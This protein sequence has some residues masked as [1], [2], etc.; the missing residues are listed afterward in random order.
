M[1]HARPFKDAADL[2]R[3]AEKFWREMGEPE[4]LEAFSHHPRIGAKSL[5]GLSPWPA[6]EQSGVQQADDQTRTRLDEFNQKY[7]EKF[8]FIYLICDTGKSADEM[9]SILAS[10]IRNDRDQELQIAAQE[11][12]KITKLRLEKL[13]KS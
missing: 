1:L 12:G 6:Q 5:T 10:R 4:F 13:L 2:H 9:L 11:Q 7:F 8:G 3:L